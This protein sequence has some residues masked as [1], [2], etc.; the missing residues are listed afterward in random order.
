MN[1]R[2][3]RQMSAAVI[4]ALRSILDPELGRDIVDLGLIY[5]VAREEG[6]IVRITMTTTTKGCPAG[7]FL[8]DA[9]ENAAW[10]VPG[11]EFVDVRMTYEPP[12]TPEMMGRESLF[13]SAVR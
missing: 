7:A 10:R 4:E 12:W 5:E 13:G 8:K 11:V 2:E 3:A 6:G 1:E 9:V